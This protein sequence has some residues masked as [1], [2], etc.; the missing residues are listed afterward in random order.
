MKL[1]HLLA[2]KEADLNKSQQA[3][4]KLQQELSVMA[5]KLHHAIEDPLTRLLGWTLFE[6]RVRQGIHESVQYQFT[7]AILYVD[8]NDF[9][10]INEAL[11]LK[12]VMPSSMKYR[13]VCKLAYD[14]WI[15]S[16]V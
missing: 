15:V 10:M 8:I 14:K 3:E 4:E 13:S 9:R 2:N 1:E 5:A 7:L 16:V 12:Q 6:D 11:G